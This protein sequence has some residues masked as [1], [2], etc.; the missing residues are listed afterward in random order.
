MIIFYGV[1]QYGRIEEHAGSSIATQFAHL[2]F[3]PLFPIRSHLVL[4]DPG[5]GKFSGIPIPLSG[6]SVA[7]GYLRIWGPILTL[8]CGIGA[9]DA[10][11]SASTGRFDWVGAFL[12]YGFVA[13]SALVGT[14]IAW[15]FPRQ[16]R[17]RGQT[18]PRRAR[19]APR[20]PRRSRPARRRPGVAARD[21]PPRHRRLRRGALVAELPRDDRRPRPL[22]LYRARSGDAARGPARRGVLPRPTGGLPGCPRAAGPARADRVPALAPYSRAESALSPG[23]YWRSDALLCGSRSGGAARFAAAVRASLARATRRRCRSAPKRRSRAAPWRRARGTAG[24]SGTTRRASLRRTARASTSRPAR[25]C[26][27]STTCPMPPRCGR[28]GA[29]S[30]A[31]R[32]SGRSSVCR[33]RSRSSVD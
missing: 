11:A 19:S 27:G 6:R 7:A 25:S 17:L 32:A 16:A 4:G 30:R 31:T 14:V 13:M 22:A 29:S 18:P 33:A 21:A 20:P 24:P 8:F 28:E 1:R 5:G 9:L 15:G 10:L 3:V 2:W 26:C 23:G 12:F